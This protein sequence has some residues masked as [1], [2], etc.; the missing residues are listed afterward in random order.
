VVNFRIQVELAGLNRPM[1]PIQVTMSISLRIGSL[2]A[3][4]SAKELSDTERASFSAETKQ[5]SPAF[6]PVSRRPGQH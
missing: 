2:I 4:I 5:E 6:I 3:S 1:A